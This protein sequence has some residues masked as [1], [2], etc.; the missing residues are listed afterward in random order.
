MNKT[1]IKNF[2]IWA[3]TNLIDAVK[4][5]A[6]EYQI[7]EDGE[8]DRNI[9]VIADRLLTDEEKEQRREL[10]TQIKNKGY[11]Q[12]M[13]EVAYTWFNRFIALRFMEVNGYLPTRIRLFTDENGDFKPDILKEALTVEFEYINREKVLEL[14]EKQD[15]EGLYKYL[16]I[17]Q[18]NA[19]NKPLPQMFEKISNY[20]ELLFPNNLLKPDS[21]L[22][23]MVNDIPEEDWRDQVQIIGWMY[24][25]YN[26]ELKDDTFAKL[27]KNIKITKERIPSA[28]QLFT[29]DWI[30]RYMI[31]NSLGRLWY[32]GHNDFD[33]S[34]WKYYLDEA[35]QEP[36]VQA[37]LNE[38]RAEYKNIKPEDI[39]IIDP[40]MGSGH[41]LV[42]AF[43]VLMQIYTSVG[44]SERDASVSILENNIYGLD[45]DD[46]AGQMAYFAVMMKARQYNRKILKNQDDDQIQPN[47]YSIQESNNINSEYIELFGDL[48]PV[49]QKLLNVFVDAKEYGSILNIDIELEDL[50]KLYNS[51]KQIEST[52]YDNMFDSIKQAGLKTVFLPLLKQATLLAQKYD[53]VCT[54]PPY[55]G[56]NNMRNHFC[57]YIISHF[58]IF[59]HDLY[60]VFIEVCNSYLKP[61]RYQAMITQ[62]SFMFNSRY[63]KAR[64]EII[65][66]N[67][68]VSFLH[69]GARAFEEIGGEVVQTATFVFVSTLTNKYIGK[70]IDL[71]GFTS[72]D[73]KRQAYIDIINNTKYVNKI[74]EKSLSDFL[75]ISGENFSYWLT[76]QFIESLNSKKKISS[77][78]ETRHGL[79]TGAG[80]VFMRLWTEISIDRFDFNTPNHML[81]CV[82]TVWFPYNKG[83]MMRR[84]YGNREYVVNWKNN[85]YEIRNYKDKGKLK[86]SNYNIEY[87]C[88][89]NISWT[90][91]STGLFSARYTPEGALFDT[92]GPSLFLNNENNTYML[93]AFMNTK[94]MQKYLE[95][96]CVGLHYSTGAV[97][98]IPILYEQRKDVIKLTK[99]NL[100]IAMADYDSF[101]T[102]WDFKKHPL[103]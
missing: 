97:A 74:Y 93:L 48:K 3:R 29:P 82:D 46:R 33:K 30:V 1:A 101:E 79:V 60:C 4:Q 99:N 21:I 96:Y 20:T 41:I 28:T 47:V 72:Q 32:E 11:E 34:D 24:Q 55:M 10:I 85:G 98:S 39:K 52:V 80:D 50:N 42:Y 66:K 27:K 8:N 35:E 31:E 56:I 37:Q 7:T 92:S 9:E 15:N 71:Q 81:D 19:L 78:S 100:S 22:A 68:S 38:I 12:V 77:I 88:K 36:E 69:L 16:L 65:R 89:P 76:P 91:I 95:V 18:C 2:A 59:K 53:V 67:A 43:D 83:G 6:F 87:N 73:N 84:W 49:A 94:V 51:Y 61:N 102:S 58:D 44:W 23:R 26:A 70:F 90:D 5:K 63:K 62:Q 17:T 54:N 75:N 14:I 64:E 45:I 86:S 13:E 25:Y 40:C 57:D 103:I